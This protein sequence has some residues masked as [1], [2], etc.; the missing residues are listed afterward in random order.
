MQWT[1][2]T[3]TLDHAAGLLLAVWNYVK[4]FRVGS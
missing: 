1:G 3:R 4:R 2:L